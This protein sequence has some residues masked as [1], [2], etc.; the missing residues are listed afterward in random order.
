MAK[1]LLFKGASG[2]IALECSFFKFYQDEDLAKIKEFLK[3]YIRWQE[4]QSR[5]A[6]FRKFYK[7]KRFSDHKDVKLVGKLSYLKFRMIMKEYL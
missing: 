5:I 6:L 7:E 1:K 3:P 2:K 4:G